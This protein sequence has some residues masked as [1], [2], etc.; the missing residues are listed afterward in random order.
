MLKKYIIT[1]FIFF[2]IL[3]LPAKAYT[4]FIQKITGKI[5]LQVQ[6]H[7][8][9]WYLN[10]IDLK[11]YFLGGPK[12]A[13]NL[14]R[15]FGIGITNNNLNKISVGLTDYSG[16]D[17]DSDGLPNNLELAIGTDSNKKDS[18]DD[19]FDDKTEII[20]FYNPIGS[21]KIIPDEK[22]IKNNLGKIFLQVE[23]RGQAWYINPSDSKRYYLGSPDETFII[24]KKLGLGI[25]NNDIN[26]IITG[27]FN[28]QQTTAATSS[29]SSNNT[30]QT[31]TVNT[32]T[33]QTIYKA[34]EAIRSNETDKVAAY[35]TSNL[36]STIK[37]TMNF[38]SSENK[39][40]WSE[41]LTGSSL[42]TATATEKI[43]HNYVYF[44]GEKIE[45]K[46]YVKKQSD[47]TWLMTN[48]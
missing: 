26:K 39:L 17:D 20:N 10:P 27:Y 7:G 37:Y 5:L 44:Q 42:L 22:I 11:K 47:G 48:L 43:Y 41:M 31:N 24:M 28:N 3:T 6:S 38:L 25:S 45:I 34:G 14:L 2:I 9:A 30:S 15:A 18:D 1:I 21:E 40:V 12:D 29:S 46:Y 16:V 4:S 8:E 32:D 23:N 35:F 19:G 13:F 36:A 33:D